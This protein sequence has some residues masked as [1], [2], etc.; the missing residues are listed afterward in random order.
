MVDRLIAL[1]QERSCTFLIGN[2]ESMFLDFLGWDDPKLFAGDAFLMNGGDRTLVSYDYFDSDLEPTE[3]HLPADHETFFTPQTKCCTY[4]PEMPNFLVGGVLAD[5]DP[6]L[7]AGRASLRERM[8]DKSSMSPLG[9]ARKL[10]YALRYRHTPDAFGHMQR[11]RCPHYI[12]DGGRC[13]IWRHRES[14][15][16]TWFWITR[17]DKVAPLIS[18]AYNTGTPLSKRAPSVRANFAMS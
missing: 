1:G 9:V 7:A 13:G 12:E 6:E 4:V 11:L 3:F 5:D 14:T 15:C 16:S 17:L 18:S 10:S 2:H 8:R